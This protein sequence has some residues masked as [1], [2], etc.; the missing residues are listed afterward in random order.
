M[1]AASFSTTS[2][3]G[4]YQSLD[5]QISL[6]G[7]GDPSLNMRCNVPNN[8]AGSGEAEA[9][10]DEEA[11]TAAAAAEDTTGAATAVAAATALEAY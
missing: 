6:P 10:D 11:P 5:N 8:Y 9:A 2:S 3:V 1:A 4:A 7:F